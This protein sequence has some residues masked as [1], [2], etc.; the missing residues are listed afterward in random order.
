MC[1]INRLFK[2][3][4]IPYPEEKPDYIQTLE[5]VDVFQSV[6]GWLEDYKVPSMH[7]DW[8]RSKIIISVAPE[9]TYPAATWEIDGV[10]Y[11]SVRPE[12]VNSGVIA[13]EQAHNSY[14]ILSQDGK[15][16][17]AFEYH[18]VRDTDSLI[19]L[20]YSINTYGLTSDIEGHAEIYRYLGYKMPEI[21]KQFYPK[22]F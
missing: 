5:N 10:R 2:Q 17:F 21:L 19:K 3:V 22:L 8:W 12:Y 18:A 13:H 6:G 4:K 7:W 14:A 16:E 20:L 9:L 15:E 11:L 1:W